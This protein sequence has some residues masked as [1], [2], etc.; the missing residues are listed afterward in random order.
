MNKKDCVLIQPPF[1]RQG[2]LPHSDRHTAGEGILSISTFLQSKGYSVK[3][4]FSDE[5]FLNGIPDR[6]KDPFPFHR[7]SQLIRNTDPEIVGI[8]SH[9]CQ[10]PLS[11]KILE[12]CKKAKPGITT[13]VGGPHITFLDRECLTDSQA[14]DVVVRGEGEWTML[15]VTR[16]VLEGK[17]LDNIQGLTFR[18]GDS[19]VRTEDRPPGH[20]EELPAV[21]YSQVNPEY[22]SRSNFFFTF[23]R[24]CPFHCS[25]CVE[26]RFWG[27]KMRVRS[28][29]KIMKEIKYLVSTYAD[30]NIFIGFLA[31]IFNVPKDFFQ[32]ICGEL[33]K[34]D[35]GGRTVAVLASANH[36]PENHVQL[37]KEAGITRILI[38][39]ESAS[40]KVL[41]VMNK[42]ISFQQ[43]IE[44]CRL[45]RKHG[46]EAGTLWMFGH[47]GE[48]PETA[49]T[50]LK[51][52]VYLWENELNM[53]QEVSIFNPY[54]GT[55]IY[56]DPQKYGI[57]I[58]TRDWEKFSRLD[59]PVISLN[60]FPQSRMREYFR[61]ARRIA[62][63]WGATEKFL[64]AHDAIPSSFMNESTQ[65]G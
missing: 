6:G 29:D 18:K 51:A 16:N 52:M 57:K 62:H 65:N 9:T 39:V 38:A 3:V 30:K 22:M 23:T 8:G 15:E 50:S 40:E 21:D 63:F 58:M 26:S 34:I 44:K 28:V 24:G 20:L 53:T 54:P 12:T 19:V 46:L 64:A 33:K 32:S 17:S 49:E 55:A 42:N 10:Y 59:E 5:L 13:V 2:I 56:N 36:L 41:R 60:H 61:E 43:V 35:F 48:T 4:F 37:M 27:H 14:V 45:I 25:Y 1:W 47:P 11:L 7:I 31:S